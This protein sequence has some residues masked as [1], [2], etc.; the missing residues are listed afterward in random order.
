[1]LFGERKQPAPDLLELGLLALVLYV[2]EGGVGR[3]PY[4]PGPD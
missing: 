4:S 2:A 1:M 3:I